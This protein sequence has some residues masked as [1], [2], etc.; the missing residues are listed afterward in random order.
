M[1]NE[2]IIM[3]THTKKTG[4]MKLT[5]NVENCINIKICNK[6]E[7]LR[8]LY[9]G[10]FFFSLQ[11][12]YLSGLLF[13]LSIYSSLKGKKCITLF[14]QEII[15]R[16][17][18]EFERTSREIEAEVRRAEARENDELAATPTR[19]TPERPERPRRS[20]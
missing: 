10:D 8:Y 3:G 9:I 12:T 14:L 19:G 2:S 15:K 6:V 16:K 4:Q 20:R 5:N 1:T 18:Q 11:A 17:R 13:I 7:S